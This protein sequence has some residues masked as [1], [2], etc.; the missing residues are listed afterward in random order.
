MQRLTV[1]LDDV[2]QGR[3]DWLERAAGRDGRCGEPSGRE[4]QFCCRV[5]DPTNG[6]MG[7]LS[8]RKIVNGIEV[9]QGPAC[10]ESGL[11]H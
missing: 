9:M 7:E 4:G 11:R 2:Q 5:M 6:E 10:R 1:R 3:R 8:N